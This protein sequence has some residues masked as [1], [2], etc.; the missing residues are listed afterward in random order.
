MLMPTKL[1]AV[2]YFLQGARGGRSWA[3]AK[4]MAKSAKLGEPLRP[5]LTRD[6]YVDWQGPYH[7][8]NAKGEV[9]NIYAD[10][11]KFPGK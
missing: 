4:T 6:G 3:A 8:M 11:L 10:M 1:L 5:D 7:K 9:R 2:R